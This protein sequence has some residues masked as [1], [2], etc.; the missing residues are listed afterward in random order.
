MAKLLSEENSRDR[1]AISAQNAAIRHLIAD[2]IPGA[3]LVTSRTG[4]DMEEV[5]LGGDEGSSLTA[6]PGSRRHI[7]RCFEFV[8]GTPIGL[9]AKV[10]G[11]TITTIH[12]PDFTSHPK[13]S[14]YMLKACWMSCTIDDELKAMAHCILP[15]LQVPPS[16]YTS[17]GSTMGAASRSLSGFLH[18]DLSGLMHDWEYEGAG[19]VVRDKLALIRDKITDRQ[20]SVHINHRSR[21]WLY[22][23]C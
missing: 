14:Q 13:Y 6:T 1:A 3:R 4:R 2:G 20:R 22:M 15:R 16:L 12:N 8:S 19:K 18:P 5:E 21:S 10:C 7:L 17:W 11:L 9:Q 23:C